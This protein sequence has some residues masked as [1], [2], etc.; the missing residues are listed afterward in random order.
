LLVE[1]LS[2]RDGFGVSEAALVAGGP[3]G[4]DAIRT[5]LRE[6]ERYGYLH[7]AQLRAGG[8]F[9]ETVFKVTDMPEGLL[10]GAAAPWK[11]SDLGS[12]ENSRSEP[13]TEN[14]STVGAK[15]KPRSGPLTEKPSTAEPS[16]GNPQHKK[17]TPG[18]GSS[19]SG[20]EDLSLSGEGAASPE[21]AGPGERE[22][23][24]APDKPNPLP[25]QR[26]GQEH[27][28]HRPEVLRVVEAYAAALGRPVR[29]AARE[30][31]AGQAA[32]LLAEGLPEGWLCDRARE[33]AARGWTDL[34]QHV[35]R[36][37]VPVPGQQ[38]AAPSNGLPAWCGA[39]GDGNPAAAHNARLRTDTGLPGGTL[40]PDCHPQTA[41]AAT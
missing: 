10:I 5:A 38:Q 41:S 8:Q 17:I 30:A 31:L 25:V 39:C 19:P 4:R 3:E 20:E 34:A 40:C 21:A 2:H 35:D 18:G 12:D 32:E 1:I 15:K 33:L 6:L 26:E 7:R 23:S 11:T 36:S 22:S 27:R 24:A 14:P 28:E 9:G 13:T 37:T 16:T 29:T